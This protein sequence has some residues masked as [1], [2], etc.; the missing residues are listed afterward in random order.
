M[1]KDILWRAGDV[2]ALARGPTLRVQKPSILPYTKGMKN[3]RAEHL[4]PTLNAY[5]ARGGLTSR[6]KAVDIIL[7]GL[8]TVN[9][10]QV[11]IP[12]Y[13]VVLGD[14]VCQG[15]RVIAAEE[16][17]YVLMNKPR[18]YVT[19]RDDERGR[20]TVISL[21]GSKVGQRIYPVGRLDRNTTGVLILSNDGAL[22][23]QLMHPRHSVKKVYN[24]WLKKPLSSIDLKRIRDGVRLEDGM[25]RVDHV[26]I[27]SGSRGKQVVVTL[28]SGRNRIIRRLFEA[29]G[30]DLAFLDRVQYAG[31]TTRGVRVGQWRMLTKVEV[32]EL[33]TVGRASK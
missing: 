32:A 28:S 31:L 2:S 3:T 18:D 6:R 17:C 12:S 14:V 15:D 25:A 4:A 26:A 9:G 22:A 8:I 1:Y 30:H 23:H 11:K 7:K 10:Q 29:L 16:H 27:A 33:R 19:T 5:I 13:R 20:R 24:V 21:L